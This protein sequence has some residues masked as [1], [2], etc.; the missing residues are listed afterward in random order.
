[1]NIQGLVSS[2]TKFDK[3]NNGF[4]DSGELKT[5]GSDIKIA[6][7]MFKSI[8]PGADAWLGVSLADLKGGAT[9]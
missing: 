1:M 8:E 9:A 6:D 7:Y 3:D 4:L 2:F 5:A